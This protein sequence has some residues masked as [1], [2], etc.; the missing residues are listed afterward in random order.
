MP[1][2]EKG[3]NNE[4]R[5]VPILP[6]V[7]RSSGPNSG[8]RN[9]DTP[10][11]LH[12]RPR[13]LASSARNTRHSSV[14]RRKRI[15]ACRARIGCH[16]SNHCPN[17]RRRSERSGQVPVHIHKGRGRQPQ[18]RSPRPL[19]RVEVPRMPEEADHRIVQ[20]RL[21]AVLLPESVRHCREIPEPHILPA[22]VGRVQ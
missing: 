22:Q 20:P 18:V 1:E 11:C 19:P 4:P 14:L 12:A 21:P 13:A 8:H 16:T 15:P 9:R 7:R 3:N 5:S 17:R 10:H 2:M 6:G